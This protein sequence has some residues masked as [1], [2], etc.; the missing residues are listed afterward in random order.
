MPVVMEALS[1]RYGWTPDQI[2]AM[3]LEDV[4]S[5]FD[6]IAAKNRLQYKRNKK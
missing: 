3:A 2:R 1:E 4:L 5:Y 6:V